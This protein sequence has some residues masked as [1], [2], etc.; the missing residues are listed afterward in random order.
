MTTP[1]D[2][3]A[4]LECVVKQLKTDGD[5][6]YCNAL[7]LADKNCRGAQYKLENGLFGNDDLNW[8]CQHNELIGQ[9][10]GMYHAINLLHE[11]TTALFEQVSKGD[12]K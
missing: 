4:A 10:R 8:H 1:S 11:L 3:R 5:R 2:I 9:H 12:S 6:A 7:D